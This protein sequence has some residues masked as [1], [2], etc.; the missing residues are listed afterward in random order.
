MAIKHHPEAAARPQTEDMEFEIRDA[1]YIGAS[2]SGTRILLK[3]VPVVQVDW[4]AIEKIVTDAGI[5][6]TDAMFLTEHMASKL[7]ELTIG[8]IFAQRAKRLG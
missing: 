3:N 7:H 1:G 2:E 8:K 4:P 6:P 5:D